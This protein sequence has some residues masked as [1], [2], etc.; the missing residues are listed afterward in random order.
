LVH[1]AHGVNIGKNSL[2]IANSMIAGSVTIG[3][4]VW[5]AP[6]T[7][8]INGISIGNNSM[9]GIGALIIKEIKNSELHIGSPAKKYKDL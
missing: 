7:S 5:V 2:I 8:V 9:T 4:N 1:I 6:S 3:E